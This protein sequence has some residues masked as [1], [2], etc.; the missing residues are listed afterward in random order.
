MPLAKSP[1][2]PLLLAL[3][4]WLVLRTWR[5]S[6]I[7]ACGLTWYAGLLLWS[8]WRDLVITIDGVPYKER[9]SRAL[10]RCGSAAV[11]T[12]ARRHAPRAKDASEAPRGASGEEAVKTELH[13]PPFAAEFAVWGP[14]LPHGRP[15]VAKQP[16]Q[17]YWC[18]CDAS[19]FDVRNI[20]Y[21]QTREKVP[22]DFALYDCVG[23][24]MV[25]DR[26]RIDVVV[27]R[28]P[29]DGASGGLP[30][31][32]AAAPPWSAS[33]GVPRVIVTNCQLPYKTGWFMGAHPE[34]DGGLSVCNYFVLSQRASEV[35]ASGQATPS[36]RLLRRLVEE[37]VSTKEGVSFKVLGR[38]VDF[39]K[40]EVPESFHKFNGKPVLLTKSSRVITS[41]LPEVLEIDYDIRTWVYPARSALANYHHLAAD[42]ELQLG[43]LVEG[44]AD[45]ELPE[46]IL[47]C[48]TLYDMDITQARWISGDPKVVSEQ[49]AASKPAAA[50]QRVA[51]KPPAAA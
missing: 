44:K 18:E 30:Q 8:W 29:A 10:H 4:I 38:V 24:D 15:A 1:L 17:P 22:S 20:R 2:P 25:R 42:A 12:A 23:M 46:Q 35:L 36:L 39:E 28:L 26:R 43:Y 45:D 40:Y 21:K 9:W 32:P 16:P 11:A 49:R 34:D 48:F 37:G 14:S 41:R 50:D 33:W 3:A 27:D 6:T 31:S 5:G 13:P 51:G 47:G 19:V 7:V